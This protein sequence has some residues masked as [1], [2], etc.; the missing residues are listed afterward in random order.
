VAVEL[1]KDHFFDLSAAR[2]ELGFSPSYSMEDA[3]K[4]TIDD[5]KQRGF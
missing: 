1:A 2:R 5:L 4:E 3:L